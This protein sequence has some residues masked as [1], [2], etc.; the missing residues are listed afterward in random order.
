[1][2]RE[3][4][5][6]AATELAQKILDEQGYIVIA[7]LPGPAPPPKIGDVLSDSVTGGILGLV[8]G[9]FVVIAKAGS[10]ELIAQGEKW[11][12]DRGVDRLIG[13]AIGFFRLTAE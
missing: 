7:W 1:M 6:N 13:R 11:L 4:G 12:P 10:G 2:E 5:M 9:P 8:P 3:A